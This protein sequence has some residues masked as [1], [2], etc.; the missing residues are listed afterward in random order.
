MSKYDSQRLILKHHHDEFNEKSDL[1]FTY[2][3]N[4]KSG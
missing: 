4:L 2:A 3:A 1:C